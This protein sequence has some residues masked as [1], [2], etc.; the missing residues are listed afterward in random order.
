MKVRRV[1][2]VTPP[3]LDP[4]EP[5]LLTDVDAAQWWED[6]DYALGHYVSPSPDETLVASVEEEL[7][8][9]L[10][11]SYVAFM[12]RHNGGIP[13]LTCHPAPT[14]TT[15]AD[16]HV[17]VTGIHGIGRDLGYSLC[18]STGSRFWQEQWEYP[19]LGVYFADCLS[20]DHDMIAMDY[21]D[22]GPTGEPRIVHVDQEWD[23]A[24]TVLADTFADFIRGL[25]DADDFDIG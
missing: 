24:V 7:G 11:A 5:D 15:W 1:W 13:R 25:R 10:P 2:P 16:D 19:P 12:C 8:Y 9:W 18:G 21:R 4:P 20:A 17:A 14:S 6:S 3:H 22:C 23:Y